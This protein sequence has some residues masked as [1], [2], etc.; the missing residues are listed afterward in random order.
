M[1]EQDKKPQA[2]S[3]SDKQSKN[4]RW[5]KKRPGNKPPVQ[6]TKLRG[7]KEELDGN[8]FDC[9][10]YGQSDRFLKTV[11]KIAYHIGQEY[12]VGGITRTKVMTQASVVIPL[13]T[14]PVTTSVTGADDTVVVAP[15]DILDI[16]DYQSEKKI[17]DYQTQNQTENR[18]KIFSLVWQQCTESKHAKIKAHRDYP[19]IE[20][21]L[22]GIELLRI[23]S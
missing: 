11:Q 22:N 20:Q 1:V 4:K 7:G 19:A 8:Y 21:A 17:A 12:K 14:R 16:S 2:S 9:T 3:A 23:S 6:P 5:K 10:D 15:P 18:Q 13:P